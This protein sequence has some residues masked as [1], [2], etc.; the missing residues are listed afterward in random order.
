MP[1]RRSPSPDGV[2]PAPSTAD[3]PAPR[4]STARPPDSSSSAAVAF[5]VT[6]GCRVTRLVTPAPICTVSV[7]SAARF[8][9]A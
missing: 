7:S 9:A 5:A 3:H 1:D 4:P 2:A 6:V 8:M